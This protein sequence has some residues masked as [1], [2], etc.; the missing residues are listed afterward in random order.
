MKNDKCKN[1]KFCS[2]ATEA[3]LVTSRATNTYLW[4]AKDEHRIQLIAPTRAETYWFPKENAIRAV[5]Y[6]KRQKELGLSGDQE[7]QK[8]VNIYNAEKSFSTSLMD[9][10][11]A[12]AKT[13]TCACTH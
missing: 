9:Q 10:A 6:F 4:L 1:C 13:C 2:M 7:V 12:H 5:D 3:L 8:V 11:S